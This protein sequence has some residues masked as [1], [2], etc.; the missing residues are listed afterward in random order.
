VDSNSVSQLLVFQVIGHV[1]R[2][3]EVESTELTTV[4]TVVAVANI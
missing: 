3:I 1:K 2:I 4:L